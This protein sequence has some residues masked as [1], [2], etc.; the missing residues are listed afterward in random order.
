MQGVQ[1]WSADCRRA[2]KAPGLLVPTGPDDLAS[3]YDLTLSHPQVEMAS[4]AA[5]DRWLGEAAATHGL[6]TALLH[7][8]IR[9]EATRRLTAGTL[10]VGFHL[11]YYAE[12]HRPGDGYACLAEAVEDAGGRS[13]NPVARAR[14]F[15]DKTA[16][17]GELL[18]HGLGVPA[19]LIF[20]AGTA[21]RP[22]TVAERQRLRLDEPGAGLYL[23]PAN[24][25]GGEGVVRTTADDFA[26]ALVAARKRQPGAFLVQREVCPPALLCEDGVARPAYWRVVA[27]LGEVTAFWW[28]PADSLT[29]GQTS[30]RPVTRAEF[31]RYR[32][33]PLLQYVRELGDLSGLEWYSTELCLSDGPPTGRFDIVLPDG[34]QRSLVAIDYLNDQCAVDVQSRWPGGAPDA[35]VRRWAERFAEE[36]RRTRQWQLRPAAATGIRLAA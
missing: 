6:T 7:D 19:S 3:H 36:A 5:F 32:L 17:H 11:D 23:K 22:L 27:C 9:E 21:A 13:V 2:G 18:R 35:A 10:S 14:T 26:A 25:Y 15:T 20:R 33:Q 1:D 30:Y 28:R 31:L 8:G 16:A 34:S 4:F 29:P 24:G 12:W